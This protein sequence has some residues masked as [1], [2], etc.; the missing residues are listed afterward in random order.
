MEKRLPF[1][2]AIVSG[3]ITWIATALFLREYLALTTIVLLVAM[4][5]LRF[6]A[7]TLIG[8]FLTGLVIELLREGATEQLLVVVLMLIVGTGLQ[9][10]AVFVPTFVTGLQFPQSSLGQNMVFATIGAVL[11]HGFLLVLS[12]PFIPKG[13]D[14]VSVW[15][16]SATYRELGPEYYNAVALCCLYSPFP[17]AAFFAALRQVNFNLLNPGR[18]LAHTFKAMLGAVFVGG[19][20]FVFGGCLV[21]TIL[22]FIGLEASLPVAYNVIGFAC[23]YCSIAFGAACGARWGVS[24]GE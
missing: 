11:W 3:V 23:I 21:L 10:A 4:P 7:W 6:N 19:L 2:A 24:Q 12:M 13:W 18:L 15:S 16:R 1:I 14:P 17:W 20:L 8:G 22:E 5:L 9:L